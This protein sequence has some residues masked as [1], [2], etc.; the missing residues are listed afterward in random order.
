MERTDL[1]NGQG[2]EAHILSIVI[3]ERLP[4]DRTRMDRCHPSDHHVVISGQ[5]ALDNSGTQPQPGAAQHWLASSQTL[6]TC[7]RAEPVHAA[8]GEATGDAVLV[9]SE[10]IHDAGLNVTHDG[11][12]RRRRGDR[13]AQERWSGGHRRH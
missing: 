4:S 5:H 7:R 8:Q 13:E 12:A 3:H 11:P 9:G 2:A 1:R 10:H 6:P